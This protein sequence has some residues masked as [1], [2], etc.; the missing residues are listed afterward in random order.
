MLRVEDE[1]SVPGKGNGKLKIL[2][3]KQVRCTH[4]TGRS[5]VKEGVTPEGVKDRER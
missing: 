4:R 3:L 1:K 2:E 5:H